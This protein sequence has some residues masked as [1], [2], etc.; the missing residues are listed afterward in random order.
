MIVNEIIALRNSKTLEN[1]L[2]KIHCDSRP[3]S[4]PQFKQTVCNVIKLTV[5]SET[6]LRDNK[7]VMSN[8]QHHIHLAGLRRN[9]S[10]RLKLN[11]I[12]V[13]I[14]L[15][16]NFKKISIFKLRSTNI[17]LNYSK[18]LFTFTFWKVSLKNSAR[19]RSGR[20]INQNDDNS[21]ERPNYAY[22]CRNQFV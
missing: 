8:A 11:Y 16:G 21:K 17:Q 9:F 5:I 20:R 19:C 10:R 14:L 1:F 13:M 7:A 4:K 22:T 15:G 12:F 2:N 6:V 18:K 3:K